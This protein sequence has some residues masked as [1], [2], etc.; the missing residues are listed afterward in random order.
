MGNHLRHPISS[1]VIERHGDE[2]YKAAAVAMNGFRENME[3]AHCMVSNSKYGLF[4]VFDGHSGT[5]CSAFCAKQLPEE[6]QKA[7]I[8]LSNE[9]MVDISLRIDDKFRESSKNSGCTA[10]YF[11]STK[12]PRVGDF[13]LKVANVGDSRIIVGKNG[14]AECISMTED[15][16]PSIPAERERIERCGGQ[17]YQDR[18]DGALAMSRAMG[19]FEYK[20][21]QSAGPLEQ[22]VIAKPDIT[23]I[24]CTNKDWV[25]VACDGVFESKFSNEEVIQ[26]VT[27]QMEETEDIAMVCCAV[28][29][30]AL[31][32]GSTDNITCMIVKFEN[33]VEYKKKGHEFIPGPYHPTK[34]NFV[35]AYKYMAEKAGYTMGQ[36]IEKRYDMIK[37]QMTDRLNAIKASGSSQM[38][39]D[40]EVK[41]L[42]EEL[43]YF[44]PGP[45]KLEGAE[46]TKWF[47]DLAEKTKPDDDDRGGAMG[48]DADTLE[49]IKERLGAS[50]PAGLAN[51]LNMMEEP[52]DEETS[53][54]A[55]EP[56][57]GSKSG[58]KKKGKKGK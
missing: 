41:A 24:V 5:E 7:S 4:G 9:D 30:E 11:I 12:G 56:Q 55:P 15:H 19:D 29:D 13:S 53:A 47:D 10:C 21:N 57:A 37:Q 14:G 33:G 51:I 46:R 48:L 8:P 31:K 3:D 34:D 16:K 20:D 6:I 17:V 38:G 23:T 26:F 22:K 54:P 25:L 43:A 28:C 45:M 39:Q 58:G 35:K 1:K 50:A 52:E 36:A 44:K 2:N 32:R 27:V 18:V 42:Q 40:E 49:R